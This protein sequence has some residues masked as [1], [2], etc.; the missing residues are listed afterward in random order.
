MSDTAAIRA[1]PAIFL[2]RNGEIRLKLHPLG[3]RMMELWAA[4]RHGTLADVV[5]GHDRPEDYQTVGGYIGAVCGRHANRITGARFPLDGGEVRLQANEGENQLHG[6]S[7]GF[8]RR[9]WQVGSQAGDHVIFTLRSEAG[10]MGYPGTLEATCTYQLY[11]TH[12]IVIEMTAT[13][14]APTVVNLAGH[15]YFNLAGQGSG[16]V[17]GQHL[18]VHAG[19]YTP[20]NAA[21][22][23]TGEILS[24]NRTAFDFRTLRPIGWPMPGPG[25]F[26]HNFCLSLPVEPVAGHL[27]RPAAEL[28][29]PASGRRLR[30]WTSEIGLQVYTGVHFDGSQPGKAG[31]RY[32]QFA[33]VALETQRFPDAPNHPQFPS[34]R[35]D[36]GQTYRHV[37]YLDLAPKAD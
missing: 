30:I 11:G 18:V 24:V 23:P 31:A 7:Q 33:G 29:D 10:D 36:P 6:G 26:D 1:A 22:L 27:L 4:D 12:G 14:T 13:T 15:P 34:S 19:H 3:A 37:T 8:D 32:L 16:S 21:N 28:H 35:L 25:G 5:L 9:L 2:A 17:L 20:V